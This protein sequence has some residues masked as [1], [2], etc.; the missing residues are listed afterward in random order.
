MRIIAAITTLR[1]L[2]G[3]EEFTKFIDYLSGMAVVLTQSGMGVPWD[4]DKIKE[5]ESTSCS[6]VD[7]ATGWKTTTSV[8]IAT[9]EEGGEP[10]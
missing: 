9:L 2:D 1:E 8:Q 10:K 6:W 7:E 5:K 4:I 3:E